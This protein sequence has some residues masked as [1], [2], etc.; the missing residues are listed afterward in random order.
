MGLFRRLVVLTVGSFGAAQIL[1]WS[2]AFG[3]ALGRSGVSN[4]AVLHPHRHVGGVAEACFCHFAGAS[5][6]AL[7]TGLALGGLFQGAPRLTCMWIRAQSRF[8]NL[9]VRGVGSKSKGN[10]SAHPKAK[11]SLGMGWVLQP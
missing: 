1:R 11:A 8:S 2:V 7:E 9:R 5:L 4:G 6:E 10:R 3:P